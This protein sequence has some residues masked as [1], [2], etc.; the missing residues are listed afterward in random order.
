VVVLR[1]AVGDQVRGRRMSGLPGG[2]VT[3]LFSDMEGSTRLVKALRERYPRVLAEHRRLVRAAIAGQAGH[4]VDTRGDAFFVAFAGAKQAVL[5]ALAIQRALAA[6]EWP[7][8]APVRVRIG[9][10]TG[11]AVLAGGAYSGLAVHRA[12]RICAAAR[13]GQ[14]LVSQATQTI[15]ED[16]EEEPGFTFVDVGEQKLKDLDRPV[17]LFELAAPGLDTRAPPAAAQL[18]GGAA[19]GASAAATRGL[20]RDVAGLAGGRAGPAE[21]AGTLA[22][23]LLGAVEIGPAGE[24]MTPVAQ[25]RL[26]VLLGL[27]GVAEGRM[28]TAE[29]LVDGVWGEEWSPGREK[30]L[31]APVYQLR[32]RLAAVEPDKGGA[33]LMRAGAGYR[34]VLGPGELDVAVFRDRAWRG[35]EAARAGD[36]A[37]ARELLGQALGLW[38]GAA[39]A[40]AVLL[41]PRLAGEAVRLEEL[42]LAVIEERVGADLALGRH[43]EVAGELAGLVAEFPLRERLAALL[44]TAL[45]RCGRRGEALAVY[46]GAR[47]VLAGE[48]G[49]DPGPELAGL[50][51]KVL[52]DDPALAAP[53]PAPAEAAAQHVVPRQLPAGAAFFAGREAELKQLDELLDQAGPAGGQDRDSP[54]GAVV[55]SA[56]A[57]MAGV[58][59]TA[60]AVHWARRVAGRFPDGQLY[61]NLRG[62]DAEGA[63]VTPEEVTGWFLAALGVPA[64][65]IPADAQAR[66][67]LYRS[68]LAGQRVL[69]V[70]DNARDAAQVRPL[71][72]G[73]A[74]CLVVVTSRSS[75]AGLAAAEGARPLRLGPLASEE[76]VQLL[77]ARLGPER[78]AAEPAAVTELTARCGHLPLALAVMAARAAADPG[79]PL[80]VLAGQLA[81]AADAEATAAGGLAGAGAGRLEALETGDPATSLRQL[82]SWSYR[83]LSPPAAAM[84]VLL[85]VHCGPDITVPAAA[86]LAGVSRAEAG[87]ALAELAGASLAAE[88]RPGRYVLHD[89]VRG[90]AAGQARQILAQAGIR[91]AVERS[92]DHYLH[93]AHIALS[94]G[95]QFPFAVAPP[96]PGVLPE[97]LTAVAELQDWARAEHQVMLQAI[98]QAAAAGFITHAWQ[99]FHNHAWMVGGAGY[100]AD[101]RATGQ[102]VLDAAEAA[103]DQVALGWTHAIIGRYGAFLGTGTQDLARALGHFRQAGDLSGQAWA[104]LFASVAYGVMGNWAEGVT[105]S[106]QAL[107]LFRQTGE[108]GGQGWALAGLGEW[109]ARLGN[110]EPAR[111]YAQQALEAGPATGDPTSLAIAWEALGLVHSGLGEPRQAISCYRQ[112]L[113]FIREL[114]HPM[115]RALL[116][117]LLAGLGDA[118]RAAGDPPAAIQAWQQALQVLDD[119]GWPDLL[120]IHARLEQVS[121][122]G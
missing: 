33:R 20:P 58:G 18:A 25:P 38:R 44:M 1:A 63:A 7:A 75:L 71:L 77:A 37:G 79:L 30:N 93:T 6:H 41:C 99:I 35:R 105:Q 90:Y 74:G 113:A 70:L 36:A 39:L 101:I 12:A 87:R 13:G 67:G 96:A 98:A 102:A 21:P 110:Y 60:L 49:L 72:P 55:I 42:R 53:A 52:A 56:V 29:A 118:C 66:C 116:L 24:A 83:Q 59:K 17:R 108:L 114:T 11:H 119:L 4:E 85:G 40:D 65:Q 100:W 22:V 57:G 95:V 73:S 45:Y 69:I 23:G 112:G 78:V 27:L 61:V 32:R 88:H 103:G 54:G 5:C 89:L 104:H 64:F 92:L 47:R 28:V 14:V 2:A 50:Q 91:A 109:H 48:L 117:S 8:G 15:I 10:H 106:E 68:V 111:G 84:S 9:I 120:G 34:L 122:P 94:S 115:G 107:A 19:P 76:G 51:A 3:F 97:Q 16:E 121:P 81:V 62:Y 31:H 43:G 82:L 26:R 46:D 80:G 86:S